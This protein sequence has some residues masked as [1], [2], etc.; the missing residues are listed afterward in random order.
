MI[1]VIR[2]RGVHMGFKLSYIAIKGRSEQEIL[3]QFS[4]QATDSNFGSYAILSN[5]VIGTELPNGWYLILDPQFNLVKRIEE[6]Q[7]LSAA[8]RVL[9]CTII[10]TTNFSSASEWKDGDCIWSVENNTDNSP[11]TRLTVDGELP[12]SFDR[13]K[14]AADADAGPGD[15][16]KGTDEVA[17]E[18]MMFSEEDAEPN[19]VDIPSELVAE[20]C[21]FKYGNNHLLESGRIS[22]LVPIART[23]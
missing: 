8:A 10:E 22:I 1:T 7:R 18:D 15:N 11:E 13:L 21:Q 4:L 14:D 20:Q 16:E 3:E 2:T 9:T 23:R 12:A 19:Y 6:L 5:N 17:W